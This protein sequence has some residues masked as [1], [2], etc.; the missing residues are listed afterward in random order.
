MISEEFLKD[1]VQERNLSAAEAEVLFRALADKPIEAIALDLQISA[2]AVRKRLGEAYDKIGVPGKGPGKL[3]KLQQM[4]SSKYQAQTT[5]RVLLW[6]SSNDGKQLAISLKNTILSYPQL[7][8]RVCTTDPMTG[9]AWRLEINQH[10]AQT[11]YAIGCFTSGN[12]ESPWV[13]FAAGFLAG[14]VGNKFI[15]FGEKLRFALGQVAAIDGKNQEE[16][17]QMLQ[18]I[19]NSEAKKA[20]E[21]VEFK[22]PQWQKEFKQVL[23]KPIPFETDIIVN[24][25]RSIKDAENRLKTNDYIRDN[26]CFKSII[27]NSITETSKQLFD[28]TSGYCIPAVLYPQRLVHLQQEFKA[29]VSAV[30][31]IGN[32]ERFW[33]EVIGREI[34]QT[35][36]PDSIR[37]FVLTIPEDFD[38]YFDILLEHAS[39]YNVYAISYKVFARKFR[40]FVRNFSVIEVAGS[41]VF[42]EYVEAPKQIKYTRFSAD[43]EEVNLHKAKITEIIDSSDTISITK[44]WKEALEQAFSSSEPITT[45]NFEIIQKLDK[46]REWFRTDIRR[47]IFV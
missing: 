13:N 40:G 39:Q 28:V 24:A 12:S 21:W 43:P 42:A 32:Q 44:L 20:R 7:E 23:E 25:I 33:L 41:E 27:L 3:A 37:V 6:W 4:L 16:L 19:T 36:H 2:N 29:S 17:A 31:I 35:S 34:C 8:T 22:F 1:L 15:W 9:E 18:E 10:L 45:V 26:T 46:I 30:A 5:Q 14:R 38:R 11:D 47:R